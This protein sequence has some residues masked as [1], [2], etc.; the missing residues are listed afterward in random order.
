MMVDVREEY[1]QKILFNPVYGYGKNFYP[2]IDCHGYMFK[3]AKSMMNELEASFLITGEVVG[4]RPMRFTGL[5][6][7]TRLANCRDREDQLYLRPYL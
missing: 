5:S 3:I 4:Q 6:L 2:C 7:K 1:V